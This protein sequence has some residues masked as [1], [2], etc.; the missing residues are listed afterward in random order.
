[1]DQVLSG[2]A[3]APSVSDVYTAFCDT[4]LTPT[5]AIMWRVFGNYVISLHL[6]DLFACILSLLSNF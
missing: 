5:T 4:F 2:V 3:E 1:V 6:A